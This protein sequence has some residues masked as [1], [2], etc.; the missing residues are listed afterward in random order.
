M[1]A[2]AL[3]PATSNSKDESNNMTPHNNRNAS[4]SRN[5]SNSSTAN[6]VRMPITAGIIAK[7]MKPATACREDINN[8]NTID[9]RWQQQGQ[10]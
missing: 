9:I 1:Q 5:E 10:Q 7:V 8:K 6:T 4:N 3:A 2:A